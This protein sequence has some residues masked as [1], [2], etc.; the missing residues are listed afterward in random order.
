MRLADIKVGEVYAASIKYTPN[1]KVCKLQDCAFPVRVLSK[2]KVEY[3]E[4]DTCGR[5]IVKRKMQV[6]VR[7]YPNICSKGELAQSP[8]IWD[9]LGSEE[10]SPPEAEFV[11]LYMDHADIITSWNDELEFV[12]ARQESGLLKIPVYQKRDNFRFFLENSRKDASDTEFPSV[13]E[14]VQ[15]FCLKMEE[16]VNEHLPVKEGYV[17]RFGFFKKTRYCD[18]KN[19]EGISSPYTVMDMGALSAGSSSG[20]ASGCFSPVAPYCLVFP[21]QFSFRCFLVPKSKAAVY[22]NF[23]DMADL[24]RFFFENFTPEWIDTSSSSKLRLVRNVDGDLKEVHKVW[25]TG[26]ISYLRRYMIGYMSVVY[27]PSGGGDMY[28]AACS[29]GYYF[30][31]YNYNKDIFY[32]ATHDKG[33]EAFK[34]DS[35]MSIFA[36]DIHSVQGC[37]F[38]FYTYLTMMLCNEFYDGLDWRKVKAAMRKSPG[39]SRLAEI[40]W[41]RVLAKKSLFNELHDVFSS[42][43]EDGLSSRWLENIKILQDAY[44]EFSKAVNPQNQD[45]DIT[46]PFEI[47][48]KYNPR[49]DYSGVAPVRYQGEEGVQ[50]VR[51]AY[52]DLN[53][54]SSQDETE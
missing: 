37:T 6:Y 4:K 33:L 1:S 22:D 27:G 11:E 49:V 38:N 20:E 7:A 28:E 47:K 29:S 19:D 34:G 10:V 35:T 5:S 25:E 46:F 9:S 40:D 41:P 17:L 3:K 42:L 13:V 24:L 31:S 16:L 54:P 48:E 51:R 15:G 50:A 43:L 39:Y 26:L 12:S 23:R 32:F 30:Q 14:D 44:P 45:R 36:R 2:D 52:E 53:R 8:E 18:S 21:D